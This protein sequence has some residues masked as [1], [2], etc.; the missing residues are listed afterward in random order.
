[1]A[2]T[3]QIKRGNTASVSSY[4]G[5]SGEVIYNTDTNRLHSQDGSVG[6]GHPHA[7]MS[8]VNTKANSSVTISAGSGLTGGGNLTANRT[9][10][11]NSASIA[12]LAK[13]DS[14]VQSV[15]G[16][17]PVSGNVTVATEEKR[18]QDTRTT[19]IA[20]SFPG[21]VQF[22]ETSGYSSV[23][24][25]GGS[26]YKRVSSEPSHAGKFQ[27][28][29]GAWWE[30]SGP[31]YTVEMF[32]AK[33]GEDSTI[34]LQSV[35]DFITKKAVTVYLGVGTYNVTDTLL[36]DFTSS[37][38]GKG[39]LVGVGLSQSEIY[40]NITSGP[41]L[42]IR[43]DWGVSEQYRNVVENL[44]L[45]SEQNS[46][47]GIY[48]DD[49]SYP[50]ISRVSARGFSKGFYG[51]DVICPTIEDCIFTHNV[52]GI[53]G[54]RINHSGPN[55][56]LIK[57]CTLNGNTQLAGLFAKGAAL[58]VIGGS[59]EGN[60]QHGQPDN[61]GFYINANPNEGASG[62]TATGVYFEGNGGDGDVII[63]C[64][65]DDGAIHSFIGCTFNRISSAK[66]VIHPIAIKKSGTGFVGVNVKGCGFRGFNSY[67]ANASRRYIALLG[68]A[69]GNN[70]SFDLTGNYYASSVEAPDVPGQA[71]SNK[72]LTGAFARFSGNNANITVSHNVASVVRDQVGV[73]TITFKQ[74]FVSFGQCVTITPVGVAGVGFL[75]DE[76]QNFVKV[77]TCDM[78]GTAVDW[79]AASVVVD[80]L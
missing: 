1:M 73:Y 44:A 45:R 66:Y 14:A 5:P 75:E 28:A 74:P 37:V 51:T 18:L 55:A 7:L 76:G 48:F 43:G 60:G 70:Y 61:G 52:V 15:N 80:S 71:A 30:L 19:A 69:N 64:N 32:G 57:N 49:I 36:I 29:D 6:G 65:D 8:D 3:V 26:L 16:V 63:D 38:M 62:I 59:V 4:T 58:T 31:H 56:W 33:V 46:G 9:L 40:T 50:V 77:R 20:E 39:R 47:E 12:S 67:A 21:N 25:G 10:A 11:L 23:G 42:H 53:E 41:L 72:A 78:S 2:N 17:L 34:A 24:D 27:S 13:A 54:K 35:C 68:T 22:V 79:P